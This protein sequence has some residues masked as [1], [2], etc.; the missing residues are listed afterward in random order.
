MR[1][2]P[3]RRRPGDD[4]DRVH[5]PDRVPVADALDVVPHAVAVDLVAPASR[6]IASI[7]PSTCA[8]TPES[9]CA[10]GSPSRSGQFERTSSWLPPMPPV[11]AITAWARER[12]L[13]GRLAVCR[14]RRARPRWARAS[15]R[16]AGHGAVGG[17]A[18]RR[19]G[20]GSAAR[21]ARARPRSRTRRSNGS[22]TPGPVPQVMWKRGTEL[23]WPVGEVAAAL[24]PAR[25]WAASAC[26]ARA[27]RRA[28]RR[29]RS[30]RR[31]RPSAAAIRPRG[32]RSRPCRAS[33]AARARRSP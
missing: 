31:P 2:E 26:P 24:R 14:P 6:A 7:R 12:E 25:G 32:G 16:H 9:M 15:C 18:A 5:G 13:A 17:G 33:P 22:T 27:A 3:H 28:S 29:R 1:V 23:P 20:G 19:R 11:V 10:G 8:G 30:R 21:R 4:A